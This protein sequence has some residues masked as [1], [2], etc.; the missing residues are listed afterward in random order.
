MPTQTLPF[1]RPLNALVIPIV[2]EDETHYF[3]S[4]TG[5]PQSFSDR[6]PHIPLDQSPIDRPFPLHE[7]LFSLTELSNLLGVEL[8]GFLGIDFFSSVSQWGI[9]YQNRRLHF[10]D[11][12]FNAGFESLKGFHLHGG[13]IVKA[14]FGGR[15]EGYTYVDTGSYLCYFYK[16][17]LVEASFI[18]PELPSPSPWGSIT[19]SLHAPCT[20]SVGETIFSDITI[21]HA[22]LPSQLQGVIGNNLL[23]QYDVLFD[24]ESMMMYLRPHRQPQ[25]VWEHPKPG[26]KAPLIHFI[27]PPS[28]SP[29][30][31]E[32]LRRASHSQ[33][34]T[35][36][37]P[38]TRFSLPNIDWEHP[39]AIN[40]I[41]E[42][43]PNASEFD[44]EPLFI[45]FSP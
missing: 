13:P 26:R 24:W 31:L 44:S 10:N 17:P 39:E 34:N 5:M 4:D 22:A 16:E 35:Q 18:Y 33:S 37:I 40:Q 8:S 36:W 12:D 7:P 14:S 20:I 41:I 15:T 32:V 21:G 3:F 1:Y 27:S 29:R 43:L 42:E 28:A 19:F 2:Y 25:R 6:M 23:S 38:G 45:S 11:R 9:D 30:Y